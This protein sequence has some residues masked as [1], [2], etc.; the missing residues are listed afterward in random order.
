[1]N[2]PLCSENYSLINIYFFV[3]LY[4]HI[5]TTGTTGTQTGNT[6]QIDAFQR[7]P[8]EYTYI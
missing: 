6:Y 3:Y 4:V 7:K 1:M 8:T 5:N 2:W